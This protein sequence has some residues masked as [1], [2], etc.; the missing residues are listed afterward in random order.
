[1]GKITDRLQQLGMEPREQKLLRYA[2]LLHDIGH[3]PLSH[4]TESVYGL[5]SALTTPKPDSPLTIFWK[6]HGV[7]K[8]H[9]ERLGV[10]VLKKRKDI[11]MILKEDGFDPDEIG[12]IITGIRGISCIIN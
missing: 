4:L 2:A 9:H 5:R 12:E 10:E 6:K 8:A 11:R 1:M 7:G 3:Y